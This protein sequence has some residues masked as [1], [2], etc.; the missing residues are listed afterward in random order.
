MPV[1]K[2]VKSLLERGHELF[3]HLRKRGLL[4]IDLDADGIVAKALA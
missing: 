2:P 4:L 3:E 1:V